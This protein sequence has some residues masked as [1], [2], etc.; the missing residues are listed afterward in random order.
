MQI[1]RNQTEYWN[2]VA[3]VKTF[4]HPIDWY[5]LQKVI[6]KNPKILD[7]GCG[8]GRLCW[9]FWRKGFKDV[10]GVDFSTK[11]IEVAKN[12]YP[13]LDFRIVEN[14]VYPFDNKTFDIV[15]LFTVLTCVPADED[16]LTIVNESY[17]VLKPGGILYVSDLP[18]QDDNRNMDRYKKF[19]SKYGIFGIFELADGGVMRILGQDEFVERILA[20]AEEKVAG[21]ISVNARIIEARKRIRAVCEKE[22][23]SIEAL[24][25]GSRRGRLPGLR[26]QLAREIV[27]EYGLTMAETARQLGVTTSAISR[28]F[29]RNNDLKVILSR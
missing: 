18:L 29:E 16:Q 27:E 25:G 19:V 13:N 8:H 2:Q 17:R 21:Q 20:E 15:L 9:E 14:S 28:I 11:M 10:M 22:G 4:N 26:A 24:K 12:T 6:P 3:S 23:V 5:K 7:Y 1:P